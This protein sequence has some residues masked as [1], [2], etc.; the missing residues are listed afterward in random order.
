[1]IPAGLV[2]KVLWKNININQKVQKNK[3][4]SFLNFKKPKTNDVNKLIIE[5]IK[6]V[7]IATLPIGIPILFSAPDGATRFI[8]KKLNTYDEI[9]IER[10]NDN[11]NNKAKILVNW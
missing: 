10:G 1:M 5:I 3:N 7:I 2:K 4:Q 8:P 6:E 9:G 11:K